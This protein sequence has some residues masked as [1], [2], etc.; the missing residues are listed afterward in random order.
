MVATLKLWINQ[1][2]VIPRR[3]LACFAIIGRKLGC[4][5]DHCKEFKRPVGYINENFDRIRA[6]A[7][8]FL[9]QTWGRFSFVVDGRRQT[10][11]ESCLNYS[12]DLD[13]IITKDQRKGT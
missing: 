9:K 10:G 13:R 2:K 5:R 8:T 1:W 3:I 4:T 6:V 12:K 7:W 11:L